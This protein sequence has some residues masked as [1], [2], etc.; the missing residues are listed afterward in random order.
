MPVAENFNKSGTV[1]GVYWMSLEDVEDELL[2]ISFS[3]FSKI[4]CIISLQ[5]CMPSIISI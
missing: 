5:K 1:I 3:Y 4:R 2:L